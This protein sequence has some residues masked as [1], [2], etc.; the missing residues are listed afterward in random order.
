MNFNEILETKVD[1]IEKVPPLPV[2]TY[3]IA[4]KKYE[5]ES[6]DDWDIVNFQ[7]S[8]VAPVA[9]DEDALSEFGKVSGAP[10]RLSFM[11]DKNDETAR[12]KAAERLRR[13]MEQHTKTAEPNTSM[14]MALAATVNAQFLGTVGWRPDRNDPEIQYAQINRTAPLE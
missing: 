12:K 14:K 2:G 5:I 4:V 7:C 10:L 1:K 13:F 8:V 11:F 3:Q 9:V 6:K